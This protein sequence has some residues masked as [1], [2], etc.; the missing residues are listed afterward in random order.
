VVVR[1]DVGG[2]DHHDDGSAAVWFWLRLP[3]AACRSSSFFS[4]ALQ[5]KE[6]WGR[7]RRSVL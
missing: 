2:M 7:V 5:A 3:N 6:S 4:L 1:E